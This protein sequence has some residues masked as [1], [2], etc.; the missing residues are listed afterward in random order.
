MRVTPWLLAL[1]ALSCAPAAP[2]DVVV[3]LPSGDCRA[4]DACALD[5]GALSAQQIMAL[6]VED[7]GGGDAALGASVRDD[8]GG[9]AFALLQAPATPLAP[10]AFTPLALAAAAPPAGAAATG[11]LAVG[12]LPGTGPLPEVGVP[13]DAPHEIRI[14]LT[15]TGAGEAGACPALAPCTLPDTPVGASASC[16]IELHN[17]S[18][19]VQTIDDV[20]VEG[21]GFSTSSLV[22]PNP[23]A[24]FTGLALIVTATPPAA[25]EHS[26][27]V[28]V[29]C[30][31]VVETTVITVTGT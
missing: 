4:G 6:D 22:L 18:E 24:P 1:S 9:G 12:W 19:R 27:T 15:A 16:A 20:S 30:G 17:D 28:A 23:I 14:A 2:A 13:E 10:G 3:H 21:E 25:G 26:A 11:V 31:T 8:V 5:F 29:R 7:V